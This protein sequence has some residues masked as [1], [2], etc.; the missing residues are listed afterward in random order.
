MLKKLGGVVWEGIQGGFKKVGL[1]LD[2]FVEEW[3]VEEAEVIARE[4]LDL[5]VVADYFGC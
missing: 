5:S 2:G 1:G 3:V 4:E